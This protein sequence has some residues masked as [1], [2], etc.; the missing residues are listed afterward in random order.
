VSSAAKLQFLDSAAKKKILSA[1]LIVCG[2]AAVALSLADDFLLRLYC[3]KG[4]CGACPDCSKV[5]EG[6]IDIM[7]LSSPK[8][9]DIRAAVSFISQKPVD[10]AYKTVLIEGADDMNA[11][12]ANSLLKT[13][14]EPPQGS[15]ILLLAR[16]A[17][18]VLPTIASRCSVIQLSPEADIEA[19]ISASLGVDKT[20]ARILACLSGGFLDEAESIYENKKLLEQRAKMLDISDRLLLQKNYAVSAYADILEENKDDVI[21]LL[22][23]MQS[24]YHDISMLQKTGNEALIASP[25]CIESIKR[26]AR[27][28]TT[29][30]ISNIIKVIFESERRFSFAVNFRLAAEKMLF[31]ILEEKNRW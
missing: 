23:I 1:Y 2:R 31:D 4:G 5:S 16:S 24:Y 11:S 22:G 12:A 30:A 27:S 25:D 28:F 10:S 13:L 6:H 18:G 17:S 19:K 9:E 7:R 14:E 3:A 8:V 20:M 29:G 21:F 15:V 26:N